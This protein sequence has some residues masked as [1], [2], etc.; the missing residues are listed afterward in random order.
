[1]NIFIIIIILNYISN[2]KNN[3]N[4]EFFFLKLIYFKSFNFKYLILN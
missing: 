1:M 2:E 3:L 4:I